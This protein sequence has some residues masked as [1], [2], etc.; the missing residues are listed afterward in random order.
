MK[1]IKNPTTV[2]EQIALLRTRGMEV[3]EQLARQ[4][5]SSVSYY[6]LSGCWYS[7]RVLPEP[8]NPREP[9]RADDFVPGTT[10]EEVVALY[11]FDRKM[12]T[13]V[14]DGIERIEVALRARI[15]ELLNAKGALSYKDRSCFREEFQH[16]DW[17]KTAEKRVD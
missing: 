3:N 4:W 9:Q 7:Y 2:D 15:G 1:K 12:R 13:L 5:L 16:R 14:Y 10:F 8:E 6:R 17:L 11:E